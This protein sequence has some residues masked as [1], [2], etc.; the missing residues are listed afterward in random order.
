MQLGQRFGARWVLSQLNL[1]I[2]EGDFVCLLGPS[3]CGKST[4]L[5]LLSELENPTEGQITR[6]PGAI[7]FMFQEPRLLPWRTVRENV[8][9]PF[10][11]KK[12]MAPDSEPLLRRVGLWEARDLFPH[13][14]SGGMQQRVALVR[15]LLMKPRW[16][17]LDEP[18]SAVDEVTRFELQNL[19]RQLW[20]EL[21]CTTIF[22]TH[23]LSEAAYLGERLLLM[24]K[25]QGRFASDV[26]PG[27]D[28]SK[29]DELRTSVELNQVVHELHRVLRSSM[30]AS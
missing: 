24:S 28:H 4:L 2:E 16:L 11:L 17:F 3:G 27:L 13:Q 7:G 20:S 10:L 26:R 19:L 22:V 30:E 25:Q 23:S 12:T 5:R 8:L 6:S 14:L 18:F 9:L 1:Q 29:G 21:G 15:A